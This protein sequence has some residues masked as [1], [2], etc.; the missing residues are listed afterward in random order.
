MQLAFKDDTGFGHLANDRM[1][2]SDVRHKTFLEVDERGSEAAAVTS[3]GF[4]VTSIPQLL[5]FRVDRPFVFVISEKASGAVLFAGKIAHPLKYGD[6]WLVF[7]N[8]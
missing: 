5:S 7:I 4:S 3:V 2:I 8:S 1:L 6:Y